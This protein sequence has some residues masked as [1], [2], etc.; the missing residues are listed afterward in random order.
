VEALAAELGLT[1]SSWLVT[2]GPDTRSY[3]LLTDSPMPELARRLEAALC[4][5][6]AYRYARELGQLGPIRHHVIPALARRLLE[7]ATRQGQR[8]GDIKPQHFDPRPRWHALFDAGA[9]A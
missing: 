9:T 5:G 8:L 2:P 6:H 1:L 7:E 4:E 3:G